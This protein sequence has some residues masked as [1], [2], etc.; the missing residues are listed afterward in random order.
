MPRSR[1]P[2]IRDQKLAA[3]F[4]TDEEGQAVYLSWRKAVKREMER[5]EI[6]SVSNPGRQQWAALAR[7]SLTRVPLSDRATLYKGTSTE[8]VKFTAAVDGLLDDVLK[9]LNH[10]RRGEVNLDPPP[11]PPA[12]QESS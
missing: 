5:R 1:P 12:G 10:S 4:T 8:A 2:P 3:G 11:A 9:K 6:L 7:W